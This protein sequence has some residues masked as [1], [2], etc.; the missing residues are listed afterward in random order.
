MGPMT[1]SNRHIAVVGGSTGIGL[2]TAAAL[3]AK[4]ARITV[5]GRSEERL[6]A[7]VKELAGKVRAVPVDAQHVV[8][9][10]RFFAEAGPLDDLVVT[11]TRR[12]GA[13]P[14]AGLAEADLLGAFAGKTVAHLQAVALAL[15]ASPRTRRSPS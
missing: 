13:G 12:G 8:S 11:V 5:G 3:L 14:A 15:P 4:G 9:L 10:R 6:A 2:A 7:A 1:L